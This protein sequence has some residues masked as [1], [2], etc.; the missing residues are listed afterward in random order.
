MVKNFWPLEKGTLM[1][2]RRSF[3]PLGGPASLLT[4]GVLMAKPTPASRRSSCGRPLQKKVYPDPCSQHSPSSA[5]LVSL[6]AAI[7]TRYL[8]SSV[9]MRAVRLWGRSVVSRSKSVRTF[10]VAMLKGVILRFFEFFFS[11]R[12]QLKGPRQPR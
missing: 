2:I 6:S 9:A 7:S 5:S 11:F 12:P 10:H 4:R 3:I 1:V 8:C